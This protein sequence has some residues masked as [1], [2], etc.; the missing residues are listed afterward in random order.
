MR[1][2]L[3][4]TVL[5][6]IFPWVAEAEPPSADDLIRQM[7]VN[8]ASMESFRFRATVGFDEVPLPEVKVKY[9]GS[10]EVALRRP[11]RLREGSGS[12]FP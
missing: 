1:R 3:G 2:L 7:S 6:L 4:V 12:R 11:G 10:M 9:A 8:L 5:C